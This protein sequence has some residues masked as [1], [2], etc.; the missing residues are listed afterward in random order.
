MVRSSRT[1]TGQPSLQGFGIEPHALTQL[2]RHQV[3]ERRQVRQADLQLDPY[4]RIF[5]VELGDGGGLH[6]SRDD[7]GVGVDRARGAK[8]EKAR[9]AEPEEHSHR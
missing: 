6:R 5:H 4:A 2:V 3:V 9:T 8:Q 1:K 7:D